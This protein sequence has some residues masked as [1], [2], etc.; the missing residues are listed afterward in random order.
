MDLKSL[1]YAT[2]H[3]WAAKDGD[4][5]TIGI[6]RFAVDQLTDVT[7]LEFAKDRKLLKVGDVLKVGDEFGTIESVKSTSALYSPVAGT[8]VAINDA[9]VKDTGLVNDDP[10]EK[11]WMLKIKLASGAALDHL[12]KHADYEKMIAESH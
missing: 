2:S 7:F 12:K 3:E 4:I 8:V 9:P 11:A 10:Y 5:V 1:R 6:T